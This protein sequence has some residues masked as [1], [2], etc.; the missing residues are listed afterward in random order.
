M[1]EHTTQISFKKRALQIG[2]PRDKNSEFLK[3]RISYLILDIK[4]SNLLIV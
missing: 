1:S 4:Y 3:N 2:L